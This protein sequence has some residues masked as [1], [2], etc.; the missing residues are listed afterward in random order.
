MFCN[1]G[2]RDD[3]VWK[4]GRSGR[5][6]GYGRMQDPR[7]CCCD[8]GAIGGDS[9]GCGGRISLF[10]RQSKVLAA[11]SIYPQSLAQGRRLPTLPTARILKPCVM[12]LRVKPRLFHGAPVP[13]ALKNSD[14][15]SFARLPSTGGVSEL[16]LVT[17]RPGRTCWTGSWGSS[18]LL[19]PRPER[20]MNGKLCCTYSGGYASCQTTRFKVSTYSLGLG[21]F[22]SVE[23]GMLGR[24]RCKRIG[25]DKLQTYLHRLVF[26]PSDRQSI[27][28]RLAIVCM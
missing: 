8:S 11:I 22:T 16:M 27:L 5:E 23:D 17:A 1:P 2:R 3:A 13:S 25:E 12:P 18:S 4:G 7:C 20:S 28:R 9:C 14:S 19:V 6:W 21:I 15:N 26:S 24:C 10:W